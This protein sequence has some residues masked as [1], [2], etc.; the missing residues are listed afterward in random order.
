MS[1]EI[2][3]LFFKNQLLGARGLGA[4]GAGALSDGILNGCEVTL[5]GGA[6]TIAP[7]HIIIG[8]RVAR[9][10]EAIEV[11]TIGAAFSAIVAHIDLTATASKTTFSQVTLTM[12]TGNTLASVMLGSTNDVNLSDESYQ[13]WLWVYDAT[14]TEAAVQETYRYARGKGKHLL[15]QNLTSGGADNVANG[16]AS[17]MLILPGMDGFRTFEITFATNEGT[18]RYLL[19]S[20][21]MHVP[22]DVFLATNSTS[23]SPLNG[24]LYCSFNPSAIQTN[25]N[26]DTRISERQV[27]IYP[28][29]NAI[30]FGT[31]K[32]TY[33][34]YPDSSSYHGSGANV[35][36]PVEIY[37]VN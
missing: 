33:P 23:G 31:G 6:A 25:A 5:S 34:H 35:M 21:A 11:G 32:W 37:G 14:G 29:A 17:Q 15:W 1:N 28:H 19:E 24:Q 36:I 30:V 9:I 18:Y 2:K 3:G 12:E 4:F 22:D 16:F 7:G 10:S 8:G 13:A 27:D 26:W 20:E